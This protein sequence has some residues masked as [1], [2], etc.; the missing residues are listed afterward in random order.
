MP[1]LQ[2]PNL[3][4]VVSGPSGAGKST[5]CDRYTESAG[6]CELVITATTRKRRSNEVDGVDYHFLDRKEFERRIDQDEFLEWAQVHG[7][8]YG[9]PIAEVRRVTGANKDC[10]L[11]IDVQGGLNVRRRFP[12]AVLVY[13]TPSDL[14]ELFRRLRGRATET[15]ED[16]QRR[17]ANAKQ[18]LA[19]LPQYDYVLFND[20]LELALGRMNEIVR[21]E[22]LRISRYANETLVDCFIKGAEKLCVGETA[23]SA[24]PQAPADRRTAC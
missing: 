1:V 2:P 18:E 23:R 8:Y 11:E 7:N 24:E 9:S 6:D 13:V 4:I 10:I 22:K 16:I 20:K 3:I 21:T 19:A 17:I 14:T 15:E 5:L 12:T